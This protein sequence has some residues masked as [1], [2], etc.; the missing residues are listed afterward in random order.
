MAVTQKRYSQLGSDETGQLPV[1]SKENG[2]RL[3]G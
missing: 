3:T 1:L 2:G